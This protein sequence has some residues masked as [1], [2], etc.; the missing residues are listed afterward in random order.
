MTSGENLPTISVVVAV[1]NGAETLARCLESVTDQTYAHVELLVMDGASTDAT[2]EVIRAREDRIAHWVS[3]KDRGIYHAWNKA[4]DRGTG[5]WFVFLG[6]DDYLWSP[7]VLER[8]IPHLLETQRRARVV[9]CRSMLVNRAG[10]TIEESGRPW[11]RVRDR[12]PEVM[13]IPHSATFYHKS[14]FVDHGRFD[15]TFRIAGDFE[16]LLRELPACEALFVPGIVA[17]GV[18]HG[19]V[20]SVEKNSLSVL[21]E[22]GLARRKHGYRWPGLWWMASCSRVRLRLLL[23]RCMGE[24]ASNRFLDWGRGLMGK[25]PLWSRLG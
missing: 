5:E 8:L 11:A 17:T 4:L 22:M 19:G 2:V 24:T 14:L 20:S 7:D 15:D 12:F 1:L 21:R 6:A 25:G 3:E 10:E 18:H 16:F 13:G 9:Y 23:R